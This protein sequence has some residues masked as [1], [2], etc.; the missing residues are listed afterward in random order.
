MHPLS[1]FPWNVPHIQRFPRQIIATLHFP[2]SSTRSLRNG[3][4]GYTQ[5]RSYS[6]RRPVLN[7][8]FPSPQ[9]RG[10]TPSRNAS[11][12]FPLPQRLPAVGMKRLAG[13]PAVSL[14]PPGTRRDSQ[15]E[16][17]VPSQLLPI[18]PPP[19]PLPA[20]PRADPGRRF[21]WK[22]LALGPLPALPGRAAAGRRAG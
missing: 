20:P 16:D 10:G 12:Q 19:P 9:G 15:V 13:L 5:Q 8:I 1:H 11:S 7:K 14:V 4:K 17:T 18:H 6:L 21:P 2:Y 3:F 22:P